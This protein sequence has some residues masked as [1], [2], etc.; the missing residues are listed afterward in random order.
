[1]QTLP[2]HMFG[3][4]SGAFIRF[5][6]ESL[7][8]PPKLRTIALNFYVE[9]TLPFYSF[10]NLMSLTGRLK[11]KLYGCQSGLGEVLVGS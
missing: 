6:T 9:P 2:H 1:M 8:P 10:V 5:L 3:K 4:V 11:V 7:A